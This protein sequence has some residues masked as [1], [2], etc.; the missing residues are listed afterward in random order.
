M[1]IVREP[2]NPFDSDALCVRTPGDETIGYVPRDSWLRSAL[3]HEGKGCEAWID[4][5]GGRPKGVR[6]GL[7][8]TDNPIEDRPYRPAD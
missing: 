5:I 8:L 6:L 2:D 4:Y 7:V 3:V 1:V